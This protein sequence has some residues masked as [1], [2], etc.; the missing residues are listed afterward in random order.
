MAAHDSFCGLTPKT[1]S[2]AAELLSPEAPSR[3]AVAS[4]ML[5]PISGNARC[6]PVRQTAFHDVA[7]RSVETPRLGRRPLRSASM[8]IVTL[9]RRT[10]G[11]PPSFD[12]FAFFRVEL[13]RASTLSRS[14]F[15]RAS[16]DATLEVTSP[17]RCSSSGSLA[18]SDMC[19]RQ[20]CSSGDT[21]ARAL[22]P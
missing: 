21:R 11:P 3:C 4:R 17:S 12:L 7:F 16:A 14:T 10:S 9:L 18:V 15:S 2:A 20:H 8:A 5:V 22:A 13:S 1:S 19:K 6:K